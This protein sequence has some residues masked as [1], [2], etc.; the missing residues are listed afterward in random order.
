MANG[1]DKDTGKTPSTTPPVDPSAGQLGG[2]ASLAGGGPQVTFRTGVPADFTPRSGK[3]PVTSIV[4][5]KQVDR[6]YDLTNDPNVILDTADPEE[7]ERILTGLESKLKGYK[8]GA[9]RAADRNAIEELLGFSN[10]IGRPYSL[11]YNEFMQRAPTIQPTA[12][13]APTI[14][15]TSVDDIKA[16]YR[17]T[18]QDLLGR[19]VSDD[20]AL[21]FAKSYQQMQIAT[22]KKA[23]LGGVVQQE[24]RADVAAEE[25]LLKARGSEAQAYRAQKFMGRMDE[26][27]ARLGK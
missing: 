3:L 7:L 22:E 6:Y 20:D 27:I 4:N 5:G 9:S 17:K 23:A 11:A 2:I 14:R 19:N 26:L 12:Q 10:I 16:V 24:P 8:R 1:K 15:V 25:A 13:R 21:A 18:A